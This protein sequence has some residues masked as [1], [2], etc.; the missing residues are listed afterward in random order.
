MLQYSTMLSRGRQRLSRWLEQILT[1]VKAHPG[2]FTL[3]VSVLI[4]LTANLVLTKVLHAHLSLGT[5]LGLELLILLA[6]ISLQGVLVSAVLWP[7]L[8]IIYKILFDSPA[9]A[10][11][12]LVRFVKEEIKELAEKISDTRSVGIDLQPN[13]VTPWIRTRCF[14]VAS[15]NY[16]TTDVLVPSQFM[17]IY[18]DYLRAHRKYV[19]ENSCES[20][21]I[22]LA[23]TADLLADSRD[24]P[25][26]FEKYE[27]W[28]VEAGVKLLH[29]DL[30][31]ATKIAEQYQLQETVDFA[32]WQR[33]FALLVEYRNSGATNLRLTLVDEI[34]YRR[35]LE[36]FGCVR[37]EASPFSEVKDSGPDLVSA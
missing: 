4:I 19:E 36:F 20:V 10:T 28:H 15:G 21:R 27:R 12:V 31:R 16:L 32:I 17:D 30:G 26:V 3:A 35:C 33:E 1:R 29:L 14:A 34:T 18:P 23:S 24:M 11:P 37:E 6:V 5:E 22:N 25:D 7:E 2:W 9:K 13:V 8:K